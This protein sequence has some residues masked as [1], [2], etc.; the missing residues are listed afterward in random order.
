MQTQSKIQKH[1]PNIYE[2]TDKYKKV[3]K[4]MYKYA[5]NIK[6]YKNMQNMCNNTHIYK[7]Y[8]NI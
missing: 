3:C 2:K 6:V 5:E 4:Y 1:I 8:T 7:K